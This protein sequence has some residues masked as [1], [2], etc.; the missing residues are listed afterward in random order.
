MLTSSHQLSFSNTK[1]SLDQNLWAILLDKQ[2]P[3]DSETK[4]LTTEI[5]STISSPNSVEARG[6]DLTD[7][8]LPLLVTTLLKSKPYGRIKPI[9]CGGTVYLFGQYCWREVLH[10]ITINNTT[11]YSERHI[12]KLC[13]IED[14]VNSLITQTI[15]VRI[16]A[17]KIYEL[18]EKLP[19]LCP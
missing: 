5:L 7:L 1:A 6:G 2:N 9:M 17:P 13:F 18:W 19:E 4:K 12:I 10:S 3:R 16:S 8:N 14:P 11:T 15:V